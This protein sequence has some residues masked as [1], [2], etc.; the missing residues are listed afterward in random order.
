MTE[1]KEEEI[2]KIKETL[3]LSILTFKERSDLENNLKSL[4]E[5]S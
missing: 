4:E 3:K 1:S 5:T 2:E